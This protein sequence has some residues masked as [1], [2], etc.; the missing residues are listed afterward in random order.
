MIMLT[1]VLNL[2]PE[3]TVRAEAAFRFSQSIVIYFYIILTCFNLIIT[4]YC[5][6][7]TLFLPY[8][9]VLEITLLHHNCCHF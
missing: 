7:I 2:F 3:A 8:Y 5:I 6:I 1:T 4:H 9:L